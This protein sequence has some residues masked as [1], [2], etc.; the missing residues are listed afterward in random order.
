MMR[1][2][3]AAWETVHAAG[4]VTEVI[5]ALSY[6]GG[7]VTMLVGAPSSVRDVL[8]GYF[9]VLWALMLLAAPVAIVSG[10]VWRDQWVGT[11]LRVSGQVSIAGA[12][13]VYLISTLNAFGAGTF[14][15]WIT[16]GLA[17]AAVASAIRDITRLRL[18]AKIARED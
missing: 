5:L 8:G 17:V 14:T 4:R 2:L 16:F 1:A 7:G 10:I 15:G 3:R 18:A 9:H 11:W 13:T 6:V 12:L